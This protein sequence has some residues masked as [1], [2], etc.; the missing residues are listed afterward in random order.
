MLR[1]ARRLRLTRLSR[2]YVPRRLLTMAAPATSSSSAAVPPPFKAATTAAPGPVP[3]TSHSNATRLPAIDA[4]PP[5]YTGP[6]DKLDRSL[7]KRT[8]P[9]LAAR[10]PASRTGAVLRAPELRGVVA[11]IPRK[12]S[13]VHAPRKDADA[14]ATDEGGDRL[15]LLRGNSEYDLPD[16]ARDLLKRENA[17]L[18]TYNLE[19]GYEYW[20]APEILYAIFPPDA[21]FD[22]VPSSFAITGHIAH[23]NLIDEYLPY[24]YLIGEVILDVTP[25]VRPSCEDGREFIRNAVRRAREEPFPGYAPPVSRTRAKAER[26]RRGEGSATPLG[27]DKEEGKGRANVAEAAVAENAPLSTDCAPATTAPAR[28]VEE[29]APAP[30]PRSHIDHF[31]MNLPESAIEFLDAFRGLY[32]D[33][34]RYALRE[35]GT[36]DSSQT[37]KPDADSAGRKTEALPMPM[38]HVHC[39]TREPE[40]GAREDIMEENFHVSYDGGLTHYT[41]HSSG[42]RFVDRESDGVPARVWGLTPATLFFTVTF[43][44]SFSLPSVSLSSQQAHRL[45]IL[46]LRMQCIACTTV[47]SPVTVPMPL[48]AT[49]RREGRDKIPGPKTCFGMKDTVVWRTYNYPIARPRDR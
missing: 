31:V 38:I 19:L 33:D 42:A 30:P 21:G 24:K 11:D 46:S 12:R 34:S 49:A 28:T 35:D 27:Q 39:F 13:V 9:L 22:E 25:L 3:T 15:V 45:P 1:Q 26:R 8:I 10:V 4:S 40:E 48:I 18:E 16:I 23:L 44:S 7:F 6:R 47:Q 43:M 20:N 32:A 36:G 41:M 5:R 17:T 2:V 29:T 14:S 37:D